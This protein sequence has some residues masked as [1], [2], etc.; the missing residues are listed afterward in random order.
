MLPLWMK[1]VE[2][3]ADATLII[4]ATGFALYC[5]FNARY[6]EALLAAIYAQM[7]KG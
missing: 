7:I 4:L 5:L 2:K 1:V 3:I 6:V